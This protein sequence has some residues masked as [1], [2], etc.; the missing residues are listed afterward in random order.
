MSYQDL[1]NPSFI[2]TI[3]EAL[4]LLYVLADYG[5]NWY[6]CAMGQVYRVRIMVKGT[7]G[8]YK[9]VATKLVPIRDT[10]F[11]TDKE[12]S[13]AIDRNN[14]LFDDPA[15]TLAFERETGIPL[16]AKELAE[17]IKPTSISSRRIHKLIKERVVEG[18]VKSNIKQAFSVEG[19]I[20][21]VL[22]GVGIGWI[23]KT[24]LK[25]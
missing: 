17:G 10:L 3:V 13:Y 8:R 14:I 15:P 18:L 20:V 22:I 21:G 7:S 2:S 5:R 1:L 19:I 12:H 16:T 23:L 24:L 6:R 11:S 4:V 9:Q 25:A